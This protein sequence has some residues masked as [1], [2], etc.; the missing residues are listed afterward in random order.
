MFNTQNSSGSPLW[1]PPP[2][3]R[4]PDPRRPAWG[5]SG[6]RLLP[7]G[8]LQA[9][10]PA[11]PCAAGA[12]IPHLSR[13]RHPSKSAGPLLQRREPR[14]PAADSRAPDPI[15]DPRSGPSPPQ[16]KQR[17]HC[18]VAPGTK[19]RALSGSA[20]PPGASRLALLTCSAAAG[21]GVAAGRLQARRGA[22]AA[23]GPP[24]AKPPSPPPGQA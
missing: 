2:L 4:P 22:A 23:P 17:A 16:L 7:L 6:T 5:G 19:P 20:L 14:G 11:G 13:V 1:A 18:S 10:S 9:G 3:R 12:W 8:R 15:R 21:A 24:R